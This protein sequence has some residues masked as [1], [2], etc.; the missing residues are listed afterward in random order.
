ME[1]KSGSSAS[2][3]TSAGKS[4]R[5]VLKGIA[6]AGLAAPLASVNASAR[7]PSDYDDRFGTI[8]DVTD[9]GADPGGD[10]PIT[11]VLNDHAD[12][13]TL[14]YFPEGRYYVDRQFRFTGF[15]NFGMVG[16]GATLVPADY[17]DYRD[18]GGN[19]R[20]FRLGIYYNPGRDLLFEGFTVDQTADDTGLR[21]IEADIAD[22]LEVRDVN[23]VG[24]H[25]SGVM[26]PGRFC[27]NDA[28]GSGIVENFSA[29]DGGA[30]VHNTPNDGERWRGPTGILC[31]KY[32]RGQITFKNCSLG[33]FPDNGLYA[34]SDGGQVRVEGGHYK[35]SQAASIRLGGPKSYVSGATVEVDDGG[36]YDTNQ[37]G[38]R[39]D[40]GDLRVYATDI[41]LTQPNGAAIRT[42]HPD[43][44]LIDRT[45][46]VVRGDDVNHGIRIGSNT[47]A[48]TI[49][50]CAIDFDTAGGAAIRISDAGD[51][52]ERV[53]IEQTK[54]HGDAGHESNRAGIWSNR[55]NV[56]YRA[57]NVR[58]TGSSLR[59]ALVN[60]GDDALI[61]DCTFVGS[62]TAVY[63]IGNDAWIESIRA[64]TNNGNEAV[65]L[66]DGSD[67][68]VKKSTVEN[69]IELDGVD[70][71][72]AWGNEYP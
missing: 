62:D 13:D 34:V 26:G 32:N 15:D 41:T 6:A 1:T 45:D 17:W 7:S 58:Q 21:V 72:R 57:V 11:G 4:R 5:S 65:R 43:N 9:V 63:N 20:M 54:I 46:I 27:V 56:K 50:E 12:D 37:V 28:D 3:A 8:I 55:D 69:G 51:N 71:Y 48:V 2:S 23:I 14:L 16:D 35:N 10:E 36:Q 19:W 52:P 61:Y 25:D 64:Y 49:D 47:G 67:I 31:N 68:V 24:Q 22:G 40:E 30:W 18:E 33:G 29:S 38:I 39:L 59:R 66:V 42:I 44:V 70:S 53:L 60:D